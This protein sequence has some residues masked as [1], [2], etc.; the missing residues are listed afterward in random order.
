MKLFT[1]LAI[2]LILLFAAVL[3]YSVVVNPETI[4]ESE[5]AVQV[6]RTV[7]YKALSDFYAYPKWSTMMK[8][9]RLTED[10]NTRISTYKYGTNLHTIQEH[11]QLDAAKNQIHS[12]QSDTHQGAMIGRLNSTISITNLPDGMTSISWQIRYSALSVGAKLLNPILVRA[13][14]QTAMDQNLL[15]FQSYIEH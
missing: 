11:I 15:A 10:P 2:L 4:I 3:G 14:I 12:A 5:I 1:I 8:K 6:P 13:Q 9:V 7:V